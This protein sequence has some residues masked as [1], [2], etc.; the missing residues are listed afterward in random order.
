MKL[1]QVVTVVIGL[2]MLIVLPVPLKSWRDGKV[3]SFDS[4]GRRLT[5]VGGV[6]ESR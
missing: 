2:S 4:S 3:L 1:T 6:R 5:I